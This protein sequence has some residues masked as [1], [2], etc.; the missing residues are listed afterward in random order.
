[1]KIIWFLLLHIFSPISNFQFQER[2][3]EG[4]SLRE[5]TLL[6][7]KRNQ[8]LNEGRVL[9]V[10]GPEYEVK[11]DLKINSWPSEYVYG[12]IIR[13]SAVSGNCCAIGQRIP[14]MWTRQGTQD[15]LFLATNIDSNG[16]KVYFNELGRFQN[17]SWYSFVISQKKES[18]GVLVTTYLYLHYA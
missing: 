3:V 7:L 15:Q 18:V 5:S 9:P 6:V 13:I 17:G 10:W 2:G 4:K 16:D 11:F 12:S 14:A 1:M 8:T